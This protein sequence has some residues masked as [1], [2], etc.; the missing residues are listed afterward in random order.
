MYIDEGGNASLS[1]IGKAMGDFA[2]GAASGKFAV[3]EQGGEALLR[4]I[5]DMA[6]WVDEQQGRL[7]LLDQ[8]AMLGGTNNA[9]VMKPYLQQVATDDKGFLTQLQGFRVSL[10]KAE[11]GIQQAMVN[12][13][14]T[15]GVN[16]S[17]LA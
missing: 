3:S 4:T 2:G 1:A 5:R 15:E 9:Q 16:V 8:Q 13:Q 10:V 7:F 6:A 17:K 12:Y 11:E 14:R